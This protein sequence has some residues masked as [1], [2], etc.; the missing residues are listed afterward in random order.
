MSDD[1]T[2]PLPS[3]LQALARVL[4]QAA[5]HVA[6]VQ[7]LTGGGDKLLHRSLGDALPLV[8]T[9]PSLISRH[10]HDLQAQS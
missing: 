9:S 7:A 6:R 10:S 2:A 8:G 3:F 1:V 5:E 4:P